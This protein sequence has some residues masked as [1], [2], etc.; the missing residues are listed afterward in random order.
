VLL[1][2][3]RPGGEPVLH[4]RSLETDLGDDVDRA[5]ALNWHDWPRCSW[6]IARRAVRGLTV[7]SW[8]LWQGG[9]VGCLSAPL[10][11]GAATIPR[12]PL[13]DRQG[14]R[15]RVTAAVVRVRLGVRP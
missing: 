1:L 12:R 2:S 7:H 13:H 4:D 10:R 3:Y 8:P 5:M 14:C 9:R 15:C 6:E 11:G